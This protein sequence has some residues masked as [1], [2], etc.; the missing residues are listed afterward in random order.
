MNQSGQ[1][2]FT[3]VSSSGCDSLVELNLKIAM[4]NSKTIDTVLC[5][6][7]SI[8]IGDQH[9][10]AAG[11]YHIILK[12]IYHCDSIVNIAVAKSEL[13]VTNNVLS[14]LG[15]KSGGI[16]ISTEGNNPPYHYLW[17]TGS[18]QEDLVSAEKGNYVLTVSDNTGCSYEFSFEIDDSTAY[19]IPEAFIPDDQN[20]ELNRTFLIY[21]ADQGNAEPRVKI[22][23]TEIFNR[24]GEKFTKYEVRFTILNY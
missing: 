22:L 19:L 20:E 18:T 4:K 2:N 13:E 11:E 6:G 23:S 3:L 16:D 1:Y 7:Q 15:C 24:W 17:N 5:T 10:E 9:I 21:M 8:K 12:N 14:D